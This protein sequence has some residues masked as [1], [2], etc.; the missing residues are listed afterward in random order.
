M[1]DLVV[2]GRNSEVNWNVSWEAGF[3]FETMGEDL[4]VSC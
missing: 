3:I 1:Q 2:H 4:S